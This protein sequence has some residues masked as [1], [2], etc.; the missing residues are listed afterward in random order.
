MPIIRGPGQQPARDEKTQRV[1]RTVKAENPE[2]NAYEEK[3]V[4]VGRGGRTPSTPPVGGDEE[5]T[6]VVGGRRKK[7]EENVADFMNDPVAGWLVVLRGPGKGQHLKVGYGLNTIGRADNQRVQLNFGDDQISRENHAILTYDPKG[8][9]FY[10]QQGSGTNL[11][12]LN[13][14]PILI[15]TEIHSNT[16]ISLGNTILSFVAFCGPDFDWQEAEGVDA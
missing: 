13:D 3:T 14:A 7:A 4:V 12:Y 8:R 10:I 16:E 11:V 6:V 2:N 9:K 1:D 15:P 5:K